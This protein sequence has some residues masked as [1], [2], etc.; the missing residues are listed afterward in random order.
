MLFIIEKSKEK[1]IYGNAEITPPPDFTYS[2]HEEGDRIPTTAK[3]TVTMASSVRSLKSDFFSIN[4]GYVVT[5]KIADIFSDSKDVLLHKTD[6][7]LHNGKLISEDFYFFE[8]LRWIDFS[9]ISNRENN[10]EVSSNTA[11]GPLVRECRNLS[12][13]SDFNEKFDVAYVRGVSFSHPIVSEKAR[14]SLA[15]MR[16]RNVRVSPL[17]GYSWRI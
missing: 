1:F 10:N 7:F 2:N 14:E 5:G 16:L 15:T 12:I 3:I 4:I 17:A 8:I 9:T 6:I 13:R 11:T